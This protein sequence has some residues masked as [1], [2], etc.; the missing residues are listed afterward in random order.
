M[1]Y[2]TTM[3]FSELLE[4]MLKAKG[5]SRSEAARRGGVSASMYD[6][7]I[8]DGQ[9]VGRKFA[10]GVAKAFKMKVSR[11]WD[12]VS[13]PIARAAELARLQA[14]EILDELEGEYHQKALVELQRIREEA[15]RN[16]AA[17]KQSP[18]PKS[19]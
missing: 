13:D 7:V 16:A 14:D 15:R 12:L 19:S 11:V 2:Q 8:N 6:K 4:A 1:Y 17:Q 10:E 3:N 9:P 5:W 18:K